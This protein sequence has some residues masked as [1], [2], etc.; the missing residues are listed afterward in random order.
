MVKRLTDAGSRRW[1]QDAADLDQVQPSLRIVHLGVPRARIEGIVKVAR[2]DGRVD[3]FELSIHYPNLDPF[4]LPDTFDAVGRFPRNEPDRHIE[5][6]GRFCLWLPQTEPVD[7]FQRPGGLRR[8][9]SRVEEFLVLQRLY[10]VRRKHN[11][12]PHWP[13]EEWAHGTEGHKQWFRETTADLTANQLEHLL[14]A[15][16]TPARPGYRCPC[17]SGKRVGNCHKRWI[18]SLRRTMI[19]HPGISIIAHEYLEEQRDADSP[20]SQVTPRLP[21][22]HQA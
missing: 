16:E 14:T 13:G 20:K 17:G 21:G 4:A 19:K 8:Y 7:D 12:L 18:R 10:D 1:R 15:A 22:R 2:P 5:P 3:S 9:I 11:I 6:N